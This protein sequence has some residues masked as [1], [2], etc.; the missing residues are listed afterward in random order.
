M[1]FT[2]LTQANKWLSATVSHLSFHSL[3]VEGGLLEK[4][5]SA[6][7][8]TWIMEVMAVTKAMVWLEIQGIIM[9]ASLVTMSVLGKGQ[10]GW[11]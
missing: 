11:L 7:N 5:S 8:V 6:F 9:T 10:T 1:Q 2:L 3:C 4:A